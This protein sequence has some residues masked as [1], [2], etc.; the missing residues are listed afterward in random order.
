MP[1]VLNVGEVTNVH[2][3]WVL[4]F[5]DPSDGSRGILP[6]EDQDDIAISDRVRFNSPVYILPPFQPGTQTP[7]TYPLEPY[8]LNELPNSYTTTGAPLIPFQFPGGQI[9]ARIVRPDGSVDAL[10]TS[11]IAQNQLSTATQ[12]ERTLFGA[13]SPVDVYRLTTLN[14]QYSSYQ[15]DQYGEFKITLTGSLSDVWGNEYEGGGTYTVL[16]AEQLDLTPGVMPGTPFEVGNALD[17]GLHLSPGVPADIRVTLRVYPLDGS[18]TTERTITGKA[19]AHGYFQPEGDPFIFETPG[20]YTIDYEARYYAPDTHLWAASLRGAG[21]IAAPLGTAD[22]TMIAHG[23]R[24]LPGVVSDLRLAWF[25]VHQYAQVTGSPPDQKTLNYPYQSGDVAWVQDGRSSGIV[26][27]IRVQDRTGAY[28][29]WIVGALSNYVSDSRLTIGQLASEDEL[30]VFMV[31]SSGNPALL[32]NTV[33]SE[34][35]TY[36]SAVRPNVTVRQFVAGGDTGGLML[37]WDEDDP[38][39]RQIGAGIGGDR[40]GD[41]IFLFG[42]A[43]IRNAEAK[44]RDTAIY[45]A[46]AVVTAPD[47]TPRIYP[48]D[49]G[50][51][52]G[53]DGGALLTVNGEPVDTFI[54]LTGV[55]PGEVLTVGDLVAVGGQVAPPLPARV[56]TTFTAPSGQVYSFDHR[57]NAI[58][59]Y[60]Q[61]ADNFTVDEAGIWTVNVLVQQTGSSSAGQIVPPLPEGSVLGANG[62]QFSI[63][64]LPQDST[65]LDWNPLLTDSII[66]VVSP[67]NFSFTLPSTW[68][69]VHAYHTLTTPGY[70]IEDGAL[71]VTGR[72]FS[73]QY[74]APLQSRAFPNLEDEGRVSGSYV[75]DVRTLTFV[76][77]GTD[78]T[79]AFQIRSRTFTLMHDRLITTE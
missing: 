5:D 72:N 35:Y 23:A 49:R 44:L 51:A 48:P 40:P 56:Q 36:V 55:Q 75:A 30:P 21:V 15:F 69:N 68:S 17:F 65:P 42:G 1:L 26:P 25:D 2:L 46:L 4:F 74:R 11:G 50:A 32:P 73:Y 27:E 28:E 14:P 64:V 6:A 58:G 47:E 31:N 43:V 39:D 67:Y 61:P 77:T 7:N 62:G 53:G 22:A 60:F 66:P 29:N 70:I 54:N 41:F 20:E 16:A 76:A 57:A 24:G 13:Q 3:P 34:G 18:P 37:G 19:N 45:G 33:V 12:D 63:Y 8:L 10:S 52:G 38:L 78:E 79:G 59:Y 71:R 9:Q